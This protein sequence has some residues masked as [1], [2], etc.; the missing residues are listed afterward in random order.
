MAGRDPV[1]EARLDHGRPASAR[2]STPGSSVS[3]MCRSTARPVGGGHLE[4]VRHGGARVGLEVRARRPRRRRRRPSASSRAARFAAAVGA[5]DRRADEGHDLEVD[6]VGRPPRGPSPAP[7]RRAVPMSAATSTWVR[8]AVT[9]LATS[10]RTARSAR[11]A[12]SSTVSDGRWARH[13]TMAPSRSP[14]GLGTRSAVSALSRWAWGSAA[15]GSSTWPARST[16]GSPG[17]AVERGA[18][19]RRSARRRC[20]RRRCVPSA[21]VA[22]CSS[23]T[24]APGSGRDVQRLAQAGEDLLGHEVELLVDLARGSGRAGRRRCRG[25]RGRGA[26]GRSR[27]CRRRRRPSR[28][29]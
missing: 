28:W 15:A 20:G 14:A 12:M 19:R 2:W 23:I 17:A 8:T 1:R 3:S 11:S 18:R 6:Q 4:D 16:T 26:R 22:P 7:R 10:M 13:A 5:G 9:P 27:A 29:P 21:S 25:A 24:A